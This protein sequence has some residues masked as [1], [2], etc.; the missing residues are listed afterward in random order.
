VILRSLLAAVCLT[1][2]TTPSFAGDPV[3]R[4]GSMAPEGSTLAERLAFDVRVLADD[5]LEGRE[6][7]Q[8][9]HDFASQF[10]ADRF[11]L[12]GLEPISDETGYLQMV[13]LQS[14]RQKY[15]GGMRFFIEGQSFEPV[16]E[17]IGRT[18]AS[19]VRL[20]HAPIVFVG[21]GF[22]SEAYGRNDYDG[23]DVSGAI[24]VALKGAPP[25]LAS[26]E[27]AHYTAMQ[28]RVAAERGAAAFIS[29][30][31][32]D[33]EQAVLP[34][35]LAADDYISTPTMRWIDPAGRPG[36]GAPGLLAEGILSEAGASRLFDMAGKSWRSVKKQAQ[37]PQ[38][39]VYAYPLDIV[40]SLQLGAK[41]SSVASP[42]VIGIIP[43]FD[44]RLKNEAVVVTAHLD[45]RGRRRT[46]GLDLINNGAIDNATGVASMLELAE[47]FSDQPPARTIVF[48]A[49][50]ANEQ[51]LVGS[52]YL[53]R[54]GMPKNLEPVL[55]INLDA[56]LV[57]YDFQDMVAVGGERTTLLTTIE[58]I[59]ED[60]NAQ[61]VD[62]PNPMGQAFSNSDHY[63]FARRGIP[64]VYLTMGAG[65]EGANARRT[66]VR[67]H[68]HQPTDDASLIRFDQLARYTDIHRDL[69]NETA[70]AARRPS[71]NRRDSLAKSLEASR[72]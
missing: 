16:S 24:V 7:G 26:D 56:P 38:G 53:V 5:L 58:T 64:T 70:N 6:A 10:V 72:N 48:A 47:H 32:A 4:H 49:V 36:I 66:Y 18:F 54:H 23:L 19:D 14:F 13:P 59:L 28:A 42:N 35:E 22:A 11:R 71:W 37:R 39:Q 61:L 12:M 69:L 57:T 44:P 29:I 34:F 40:G 9:G 3:A 8:R 62:D 43:G 31:T 25:F 50:T 2:A 67:A 17:L 20:A 55:N 60:H 27:R 21:W 33:E 30:L 45:H 63:S 1:V 41:A 51:G 46:N 15:K 68:H 65:G 52:D